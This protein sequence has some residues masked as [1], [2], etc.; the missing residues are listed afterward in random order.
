MEV[1]HAELDLNALDR[2][3]EEEDFFVDP[4]RCKRYAAATNDTNSRHV[5]GELAPPIFAVVA[6]VPHLERGLRNLL[7]ERSRTGSRG[8]HGEQDMFFHRPLI[9]G[10]TLRVRARP[11]GVH[12]RPTGTALV[13]YAELRDLSGTVVHEQYI[14]N[15]LRG[16]VAEETRGSEAPNHRM[17]AD[18]KLREPAFS[19]RYQTDPDQTYRYAEASGD[20]SAYHVN[21]DA[22]RAG[23]WPGIILHGLCTM[24][25]VSRAVVETTCEGDP[26]RLQ[27][28]AVRFSHP[29]FPAE[30]ITTT[31]WYG[32][33][34][35]DRLTHYFETVNPASQPVITHGLAEVR[36]AGDGTA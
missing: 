30:S 32:T 33:Q 35:G 5:S 29:V 11:I 22:A 12:Q 1:L 36:E 27:R 17:P 10:T 18:V 8:V 21:E 16:V 26:A 9:P 3:T 15:Y 7:P 31:I 6:T 19:L 20:H 4:E 25:F 23:G 28:L 13:S 34:N 2:W 14:T 24:A